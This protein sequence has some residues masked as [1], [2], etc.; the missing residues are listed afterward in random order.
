MIYSC[1]P[2]KTTVKP[3]TA[4]WL[5]L[6]LDV[7][8]HVQAAV[9]LCGILCVRYLFFLLKKKTTPFVSIALLHS[10]LSHHVAFPLAGTQHTPCVI[11]DIKITCQNPSILAPLQI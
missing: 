11:A 3:N 10:L 6:F 7:H 1:T 5:S 8:L 4:L 2:F 9:F